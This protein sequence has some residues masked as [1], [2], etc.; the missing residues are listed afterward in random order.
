MWG[1]CR[2]VGEG[3]GVLEDVRGVGEERRGI[4][5]VRGG[6]YASVGRGPR[7]SE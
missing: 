3:Q 7:S 2:G 5:H 4:G 1:G 6:G